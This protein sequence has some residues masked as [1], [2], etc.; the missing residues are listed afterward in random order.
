MIKIT[1]LI[2]LT[3]LILS[4]TGKENLN[5]KAVDEAKEYAI[6]WIS[7]LDN[8]TYDEAYSQTA[9]YFKSKV[10]ANEWSVSM[11]NTRDVVGGVKRRFLALTSYKTNLDN[12]PIGEY[13]ILRYHTAFEKL[14]ASTETLT[15]LKEGNVWKPTGYYIR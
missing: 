12:A 11:K 4:C 3:L 5:A 15:M 2:F 7:L 8:G 6:S 9:S 10:S 14:E 1:P 13:V